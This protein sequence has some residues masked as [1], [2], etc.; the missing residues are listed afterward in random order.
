MCLLISTHAAAFTV[1]ELRTPY[2]VKFRSILHETVVEP[3]ATVQS[4]IGHNLVLK[5]FD[6]FDFN[7]TFDPNTRFIPTSEFSDGAPS[8]ISE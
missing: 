7:L 8:F 3:R 2:K 6:H 1:D 4:E 5:V